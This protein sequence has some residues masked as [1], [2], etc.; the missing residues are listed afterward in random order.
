[1]GSFDK[2]QLKAIEAND[3]NEIIL[4]VAGSG[5]TTTTIACVLRAL[6]HPAITKQ[7]SD[8][9]L[10]QPL[11]PKHI[12][13]ASFTNIAANTFKDRLNQITEGDADD[14]NISTLDKFAIEII[15]H[16]YPNAK[17]DQNE[18]V[19]AR[20]LYYDLNHITDLQNEFNQYSRY[21]QFLDNASNRFKTTSDLDKRAL[22]YDNYLNQY[23]KHIIETKQ[24]HESFT[25]PLS[26]IYPFAI[27]TMIKHRFIPETEL[28]IVDEIQDT[29]DQQ[30]NF[31]SFLRTQLPNMRF[32]GVGDV[33]QSMYRWNQAQP[34]RVS[35]FIQD[36]NAKI[37]TL[38]NNYRSHSDIIDYA[39]TM[40]QNNLDNISGITINPKS[41]KKH[42][43]VE[44]RV[45]YQTSVLKMIEDIKDKI[46]N[47][48]VNPK[49]IAIIAR[50][51]SPLRRINK[52]ISINPDLSIPLD[53]SQQENSKDIKFYEYVLRQIAINRALL[54]DNRFDI[55][56][57]ETLY[58]QLRKFHLLNHITHSYQY[59]LNIVDSNKPRLKR[60]LTQD[61]DRLN[62]FVSLKM[63]MSLFNPNQNN[64]QN[65]VRLSTVHG[66]KGDEYRYVYYIPEKNTPLKDVNPEKDLTIAERE[67]FWG[68][69]AERQNIHYVAI[70]RAIDQFT[71]VDYYNSYQS[72]LE[73]INDAKLNNKI[74]NI[75]TET[76]LSP[77]AEIIKNYELTNEEYDFNQLL[78][79]K[80]LFHN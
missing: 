18:D 11:N 32:I 9:T 54:N 56:Q 60:E 19:I 73:K 48:N 51:S 57:L 35:N 63:S 44:H 34:E 61:L 27:V 22:Y 37:H 59:Y 28:L 13:V 67:R 36:F 71:L 4:A 29:S 2:E 42:S 62:D 41:N 66:I 68:S 12:R 69:Y 20:T 14:V 5:K 50:N 40:L 33:S 31:I 53:M 45:N 25:I 49:D 78:M 15:Q 39:N 17:F 21:I 43:Y 64:D 24:K 75:D 70:T 79:S 72:D 58:Y 76:L 30:F 80:K 26:I 55:N 38:P 16:I 7:L 77:F 6:N 10:L 8:N 46:E 74:Y 23:L 3:L 65:G 1:M 52:I 47:Y